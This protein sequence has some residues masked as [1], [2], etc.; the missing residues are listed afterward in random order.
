MKRRFLPN[1]ANASA[2]KNSLSRN[3]CLAMAALIAVALPF[4]LLPIG[5]A[6]RSEPQRPNLD[7]AKSNERSAKSSDETYRVL[8]TATKCRLV[9]MRRRKKWSRRG[10]S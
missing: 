4:L 5:I 3:T 1:K 10:Q 9:M 8:A 2:R 6:K 7:Q